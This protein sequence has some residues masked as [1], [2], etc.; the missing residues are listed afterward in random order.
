MRRAFLV[1][2]IAVVGLIIGCST[3]SEKGDYIIEKEID[4][5]IPM[6]LVAKNISEEDSKTK[7]RSDFMK[8]GT[9]LMLYHIE[10]TNLYTDLSVGE[11][12][13]VE[14]KM[15]TMDGKEITH[16]MLSDPPQTVAGKITRYS[17]R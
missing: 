1:L 10:D 9:D 11:R 13:S 17:I 2:T 5:N 16:V 3:Q 14:A 15:T 12:V 6:I 8:D 4:S 7:S